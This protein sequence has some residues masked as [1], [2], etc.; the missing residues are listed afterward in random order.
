MGTLRWSVLLL[1]TALQIFIVNSDEEMERLH[2]DNALAFR[3]DQRSLYFKD[4]DGWFPIQVIR[5]IDLNLHHS[6]HKLLLKLCKSLSHS[7]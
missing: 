6:P 3:K 1:C 7:S 4:L 5:Q 2:A